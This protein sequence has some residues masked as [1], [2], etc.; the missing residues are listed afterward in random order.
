MWNQP[1]R[2]TGELIEARI[3]FAERRHAPAGWNGI[4]ENKTTRLMTQRKKL[5]H[6]VLLGLYLPPHESG[7]FHLRLSD[8]LSFFWQRI[9]VRSAVKRKNDSKVKTEA[10]VPA[11]DSPP[12]KSIGGF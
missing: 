5:L 12:V 10:G 2:E 4:N 6:D 7:E 8:D 9:R 11:A 1:S 3:P